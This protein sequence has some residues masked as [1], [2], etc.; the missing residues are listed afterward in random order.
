MDENYLTQIFAPISPLV[1]VRV[2]RDKMTGQVA[3]YGFLEFQT[4]QAAA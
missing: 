4:P 1:N 2:I 3:G